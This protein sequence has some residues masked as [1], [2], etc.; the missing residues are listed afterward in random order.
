MTTSAIHRAAHDG[1]PDDLLAALAAGGSVSE[2]SSALVTTSRWLYGGQSQASDT[3]LQPMH[4]AAC[5]GHASLIPALLE[6]GADL[7]SKS[8]GGR[9]PLLFACLSG[10]T[11]IAKALLDAGADVAVTDARGFGALHCAASEGHPSLV[12]LLI[13]R[14]APLDLPCAG[15]G[16]IHHAAIAAIQ[17]EPKIHG[18]SERDSK[19]RQIR[20][21]NGQILIAGKATPWETVAQLADDES[22]DDALRRYIG[23]VESARILAAAGADRTLTNGGNTVEHCFAELGEPALVAFITNWTTTNDVGSTPSH[24]LA[25]CQREDGVRAGIEGGADLSVRND[26]G[27]RP[28]HF[29][30]DKGGPVAVLEALVA[31]GADPQ[32]RITGSGTYPEGWTPTDI[33]KKWNDTEAVAALERLAQA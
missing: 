27:L 15:I 2:V 8:K 26:A 20:V 25:T 29:F 11:S 23:L 30:A 17:L 19:G 28:I 13:A 18:R 4:V 1:N 22:L 7:E 10:S 9:T 16:A 12:E 33:A 3:Q 32:D 24:G 14:G 31:A 6:A 5:K 21:V